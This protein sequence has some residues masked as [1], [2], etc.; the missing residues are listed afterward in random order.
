[1][2]AQAYFV[3]V[4]VRQ[5]LR[6]LGALEGNVRLPEGL[7]NAQVRDV[8]D[9]L[10]HWDQ[11]GGR[12]TRAMAPSGADPASHVWTE[13]GRVCSVR[14]SRT[15]CSA[16]GESTSTRNSSAGI[17]TTGGAPSDRRPM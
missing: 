8:R 14:S 7:T 6:S 11:P 9:A 12:A 13:K 17:R 16:S 3:L 10:E 1:M 2:D 4:A 15:P 5:L